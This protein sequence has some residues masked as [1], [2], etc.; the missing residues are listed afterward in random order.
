MNRYLFLVFI[1]TINSAHAVEC[2]NVAPKTQISLLFETIGGNKCDPLDQYTW[3]DGW[4]SPC[5]CI[6]KKDLSSKLQSAQS[7]DN[8]SQVYS[9]ISKHLEIRVAEAI[10]TQIY[11]Q[12]EQ[13]LR[14]D[15]FLKK[16]FITTDQINDSSNPNSIKIPTS[17][18]VDKIGELISNLGSTNTARKSQC[19]PTVM[20]RRLKLLFY[21]QDFKSWKD[22][23]NKLVTKTVMNQIDES[24]K[25]QGICIPYKSFLS[26]SNVNP[27]RATYL[28]VAK[29]FGSDF[30]GFQDWVNNRSQ[31]YDSKHIV[32]R[33]MLKDSKKI[34][35]TKHP[36]SALQFLEKS[37]DNNQMTKKVEADKL[38]YDLKSGIDAVTKSDILQLLKTDPVF[39]RMVKDPVFYG[40]IQ[41]KD[42][43]KVSENDPRVIKLMAESLNRSCDDLYGGSP[44]INLE[45]SNDT[46]IGRESVDSKNKQSQ[47]NM[48]TKYLCDEDYPKDFV[49][50]RLIKE[51]LTNRLQSRLKL[52]NKDDTELALTDYLYCKGDRVN[53]EGQWD[54]T[55]NLSLE[56]PKNVKNSNFLNMTLNPPSDIR[57]QGIAAG[58][59]AFKDFNNSVC[60]YLPDSCKEGSEFKR[61]C[62]STF[63]SQKVLNDIISSK[64]DKTKEGQ[65]LVHNTLMSEST[66]SKISDKEFKQNLISSKR[67]TTDEINTLLIL[68]QQTPLIQRSRAADDMRISLDLD[69]GTKLTGQMFQD[70]RI[71]KSQRKRF[72]NPIEQGK[73]D[74]LV[75][76]EDIN[77]ET[78]SYFSNY[79]SLASSDDENNLKNYT[80]ST[81]ASGDG[82]NTP[83][84]TVSSGQA[85]DK[86]EVVSGKQEDVIGKKEE[87]TRKPV[88]GSSNIIT[89]N[90]IPVANAPKKYKRKTFV[91]ET[92]LVADDRPEEKP[93]VT[94]LPVKET[95]PATVNDDPKKEDPDAKV[96]AKKVEKPAVD[97]EPKGDTLKQVTLSNGKRQ[98][99]SY[100]PS[101]N[102]TGQKKKE[103]LINNKIGSSDEQK[104]IT[105]LQKQIDGLDKLADQMEKARNSDEFSSKKSELDDLKDE[106]EREKVNA[107]NRQKI[108]NIQ[109]AVRNYTNN[110][111]NN[112]NYSL[113]NPNATSTN[114]NTNNSIN[115]ADPYDPMG[116]VAT[117]RT[118][119]DDE[120]DATANAGEA[121]APGRS[122]A[123]TTSNTNDAGGASGGSGG[124]ASS[125]G[126]SGA[127]GGTSGATSGAG[128]RG[129][130]YPTDSNGENDP[131][132]VCG[133]DQELNC[134]FEHQSTNEDS[135]S[136]VYAPNLSYFIESLG[137]YGKSFKTVEVYQY[138]KNNKK[139]RKYFVHYLEA[140]ENLSAEDKALIYKKSL[141]LLKDYK[142]NRKALKE[143]SKKYV[144]VRKVEIPVSEAKEISR[145]TLKLKD[146]IKLSDR[147]ARQK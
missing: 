5:D 25:K 102:T 43:D 45:K 85:L 138:K 111:S 29:A 89:A 119:K 69:K 34:T 79:F 124:L 24:D 121:Q 105:D 94:S 134:Y 75:Q 47:K 44:N 87:V 140:G 98:N 56:I 127:V 31:P 145:I 97:D 142:A 17:C 13:N 3:D 120:V 78:S 92:K 37:F 77:D 86:G 49:D 74:N 99:S 104:K 68:R 40:E 101:F 60:K 110:K 33:H 143:I 115:Y 67:F 144:E 6:N 7:L 22:S 36:G 126:A 108:S 139:S 62:T 48:L 26:L 14:L 35:E 129:T 125:S 19:D 106:L 57:T 71:P 84:I 55:S 58:K 135:G 147:R 59:S 141:Y 107:K 72:F 64:E 4:K 2:V 11:N 51:D 52:A 82:A 128:S 27:L 53:T 123:S 80:A 116:R 96:A 93:P 46:S 50:P 9:K 15:I 38:E 88:E 28:Q 21:G 90:D 117:G 146:L 39:E 133:Y 54:L 91:E 23:N 30:N 42:V 10:R 83:T 16:G 95:P 103:S 112:E 70:E 73:N 132:D 32:S 66:D 1:S 81:L 18:R 63:F 100:V 137:L 122:S 41:A 131:D 65:D 118:V 61:T 12:L 130:R 8:S 20:E 109:N 113:G 76:E 136:A 114:T